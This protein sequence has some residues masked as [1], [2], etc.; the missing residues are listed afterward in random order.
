MQIV[1][2]LATVK[3]AVKKKKKKLIDCTIPLRALLQRSHR[4]HCSAILNS[5]VNTDPGLIRVQGENKQRERRQIGRQKK[6][7]ERERVRDV[8]CLVEPNALSDQ[9]A[10]TDNASLPP[11]DY[12]SSS[13]LLTCSHVTLG[14]I[15]H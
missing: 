15:Q 1:E 11:R 12:V 6:K 3:E 5:A 9:H 10:Q 13:S 8:E 14:P 7:K 4:R 2:N